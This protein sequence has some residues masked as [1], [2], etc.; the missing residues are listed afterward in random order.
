[1][2][3]ADQS[4]VKRQKQSVSKKR[5]APDDADQSEANR[6]KRFKEK[7]DKDTATHDSAQN[8]QGSAVAK[9]SSKKVTFA[10]ELSIE[11]V[12]DEDPAP[13]PRKTYGR[14]R[15]SLLDFISGIPP[16]PPKAKGR[17]RHAATRAGPATSGSSSRAST[18]GPEPSRAIRIEKSASLAAEGI[19]V[20][21]FA[22]PSRDPAPV[23]GLQPSSGDQS[24]VKDVAEP[25]VSLQ[26]STP[27]C[28]AEETQRMA[29]GHSSPTNLT[30]G[31]SESNQIKDPALD[32]RDSGPPE[33]LSKFSHDESP[34]EETRQQ[35]PALHRRV[36][37]LRGG[38]KPN[39]VR[40]K[41]AKAKRPPPATN[42]SRYSLRSGRKMAGGNGEAEVKIESAE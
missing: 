28:D 17:A 32:Y 1:M 10:P 11:D 36:A 6:Q 14:S 27:L 13:R 38:A 25:T 9:K 2:K 26:K 3:D 39:G 41:K 20:V 35:Q 30:T 16:D 29:S 4:E 40:K 37:Q 34:Q 19:S 12:S 33:N 5:S 7:D 15:Q 23:E 24:P 18:P 21:D 22:H 31:I 8:A 42:R